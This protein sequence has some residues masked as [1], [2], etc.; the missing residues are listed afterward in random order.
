M[1]PIAK[2]LVATDFSANGNN[3]VWRAALL[4]RHLKARLMLL[5]VVNTARKPW[6]RWLKRPLDAALE[7]ARAQAALSWLGNELATAHEVTAAVDVR[8]GNPREE[9]LHACAQAD[10]LVLGHRGRIPLLPLARGCMAERVLRSGRTP[11]LVVKRDAEVPYRQALVP[12][13]FTPHA[14]AAVQVASS[15]APEWGTQLFHPIDTARHAVLRE[16]DAAEVSLHKA[17]ARDEAHV[18]ARMRRSIARLGLDARRMSFALGHGAPLPSTLRQLRASAADLVVVGKPARSATTSFALAKLSRGLL[19]AA[20]C[21]TVIV[22]CV[23]RMAMP[24]RA[25]PFAR[26]PLNA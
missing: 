15:L 20:D 6:Q 16:A 25:S 11:V 24:L 3:A 21:D 4:A 12:M 2:I 10:L 17:R 18:N 7:A 22:P 8:I 23:E 13:D 26:I 9:L 19:A 14:D 5:H 1:A